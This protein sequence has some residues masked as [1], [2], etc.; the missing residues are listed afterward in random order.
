MQADSAGGRLTRCMRMSDARV[1]KRNPGI[2][3]NQDDV[4][5][6]RERRGAGW[7][8]GRGTNLLD[9]SIRKPDFR[10]RHRPGHGALVHD[11]GQSCWRSGFVLRHAD[12]Q[13]DNG[14][15]R[16]QCFKYG[17]KINIFILNH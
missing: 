16:C 14:L 4:P 5:F 8:V 7:G 17:L 15:I 3:F 2:G 9:A 12:S 13:K 11:D 6:N 1:A 10:I